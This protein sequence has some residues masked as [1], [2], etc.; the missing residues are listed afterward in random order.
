MSL[1]APNVGEK[2]MLK[3]FLLS[4]AIVLGLYKNVIIPD[5]NTIFST[6][7]EMASGAGEGYVQIPLSRDIVENTPTTAK[8]YITT[9]ANGKAVAQYGLAAAPQAWTFNAVDVAAIETVYGI[10]GFTWVLPFDA[11]VKEIKVGDTIK[12]ATS[13]ATGIVT[14]V[15]VQSGTWAAGT[16]AGNLKIMTKTGTFQNNENLYVQ[17]EILTLVAAPTAAGDTYSVGDT[18]KITT[19]GEGG[20]GFVLTLTGGDNT[21]VATIGVN[22]GAGGRNYA[23]GAGKATVK[24]NGGGNDALTVEI[25]SLATAAYAV[26]NTGVTGDALKQLLFTENFSTGTLVTTVGQ[27]V[28]Y[29]PIISLA[30]AT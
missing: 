22:P 18:F 26:S 19:G 7:T 16:A 30:T 8:W 14:G 20:I 11:G 9:D 17:G 25:A 15:E 23:I 5:G 2:E 1:Y 27:Q 6:L 29:L 24:L 3:D 28:T 12:G 13:A 4:Q 21:P 10:F